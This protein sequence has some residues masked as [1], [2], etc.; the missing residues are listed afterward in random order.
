MKSTVAQVV[1]NL[2]PMDIKY[3]LKG[4]ESISR[5][6]VS[7]MFDEFTPS[8]AESVAS[9]VDEAITSAYQNIP[10]PYFN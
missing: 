4:D 2:S 9:R 5:W 1:K 3:I 6:Y 10:F 8:Q 7:K